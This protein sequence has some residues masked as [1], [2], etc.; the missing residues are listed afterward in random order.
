[1]KTEN[2]PIIVAN[3][4]WD[5]PQNLID[6]VKQERM[7]NSLL[8]LMAGGKMDYK[9]LV[10]DAEVVAYLNPA[11]NRTVLRADVVDIYLYC[12]KRM[13]KQKG[14]D[15]EEQIGHKIDDLNDYKIKQLNKLKSWIYEKRGGR[16]RNPV[17]SALKEV[18]AN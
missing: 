3:K 11:T 1:M 14:I 4:E 17:I 8:D 16:E 7:I 5:L 6:S 9:D 18:F 10:G 12:F 15:A 13:M 2:T